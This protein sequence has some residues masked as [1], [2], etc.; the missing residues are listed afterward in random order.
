MPSS[1]VI[2][3][4]PAGSNPEPKNTGL[5]H[6]A[7]TAEHR[8]RASVFMGSGCAALLRPG[9]TLWKEKSR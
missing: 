9:M 3:G 1:F 5:A 6:E 8:L 7:L 2:P 4:R